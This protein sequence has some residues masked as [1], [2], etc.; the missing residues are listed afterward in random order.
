MRRLIDHLNMLALRPFSN[1]GTDM[2]AMRLAQG[3][4]RMFDPMQNVLAECFAKEQGPAR[5]ESRADVGKAEAS[6]KTTPR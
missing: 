2:S 6:R 3:K 4:V 5:G 1:A